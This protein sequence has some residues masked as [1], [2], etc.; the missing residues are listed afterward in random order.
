MDILEGAADQLTRNRNEPLGDLGGGR[1]L[2]APAEGEQGIS[3]RPDDEPE[4]VPPGDEVDDARAFAD[5]DADD[6][7]DDDEDEDEDEDDDNEDENAEVA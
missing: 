6:D 7:D 3:N 5:D 2:W 4:G 1:R